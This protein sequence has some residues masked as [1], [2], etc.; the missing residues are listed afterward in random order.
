MKRNNKQA[1]FLPFM[2]LN[3]EEK[4]S[5]GQITSVSKCSLLNGTAQGLRHSKQSLTDLAKEFPY[6][7]I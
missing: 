6:K 3:S 7:P 2:F 4:I 1:H 5:G